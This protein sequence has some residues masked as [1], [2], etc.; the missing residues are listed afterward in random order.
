MNE[1]DPDI[2]KVMLRAGFIPDVATEEDIMLA[3]NALAKA[4]GDIGLAAQYYRVM[5]EARP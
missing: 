3:D 1:I 2:V 4:N 5:K